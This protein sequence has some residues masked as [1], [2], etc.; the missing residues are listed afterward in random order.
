MGVSMQD[1]T[2]I[3]EQTGSRH[4]RVLVRGSCHAREEEGVVCEGEQVIPQ[5]HAKLAQGY[6]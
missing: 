4:A 6:L 5:T 1:T 2:P 3:D